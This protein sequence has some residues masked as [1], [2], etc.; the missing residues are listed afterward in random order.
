MCTSGKINAH[1]E[2]AHFD[3][4]QNTVPFEWG[5]KRPDKVIRYVHL[6]IR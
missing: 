6:P 5:G 4:K 2:F 1:E 3:A